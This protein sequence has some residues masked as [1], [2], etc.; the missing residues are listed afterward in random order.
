MKLLEKEKG[1]KAFVTELTNDSF[2]YFSSVKIDD[3]HMQLN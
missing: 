2:V 1:A 3:M